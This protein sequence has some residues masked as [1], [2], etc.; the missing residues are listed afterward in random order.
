MRFLQFMIEG[1]WGMWFV[2]TFGTITLLA[3]IGF[4]RKPNT[5]RQHAAG[6]FCGATCFAILSAV[7]LNLAAVGSKVP[8]V[9]EWANSPRVHLIVME[10]ISESL[11]PAILGFTLLSF[12][13][14]LMAVGQRRWQREL[15]RD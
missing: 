4:A 7:S 1:G 8:N 13:W 15:P 10:G 6:S 5:T 9:P 3:A 14:M 11:A 12:A 2:L